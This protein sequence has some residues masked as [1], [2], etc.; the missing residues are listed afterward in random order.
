MLSH[1]TK[2]NL[3]ST[4]QTVTAALFKT[5]AFMAEALTF[6]YLGVDFVLGI[7]WGELNLYQFHP[8]HIARVWFLLTLPY[9]WM[10][11]GWVMPHLQVSHPNILDM[12]ERARSSGLG[13][14]VVLKERA[15]ASGN[16]F[17]VGRIDRVTY[18]DD[19]SRAAKYGDRLEVRVP[20]YL[21]TSSLPSPSRPCV[22]GKRRR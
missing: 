4:S 5:L 6:A 2:H 13:G 3:T 10:P 15:E 17:V 19:A 1:Y 8:M 7:Q 20:C 14:A 18:C 11:V 12:F 9:V 16:A 22:W 21:H